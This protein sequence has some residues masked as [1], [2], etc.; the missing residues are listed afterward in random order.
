MIGDGSGQAR[1]GLVLV[2]DRLGRNR[3]LCSAIEMTIRLLF[4][5][6]FPWAYKAVLMATVMLV[7][8][9]CEVSRHL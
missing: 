6:T 7:L 5:D 8:F 4:R 2:G 3:S 9:P 1:V